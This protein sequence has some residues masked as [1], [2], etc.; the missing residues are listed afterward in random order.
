M[1]VHRLLVESV[2]LR[3]L[4]R[5]PGGHDVLRARVDRCPEATGQK[6]PGSLARKGACDSTADR[7]SG[8]VDHPNLVVEQ[9]LWFP[10]AKDTDTMTSR[11]RAR[12]LRPVSASIRVNTGRICAMTRFANRVL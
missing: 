6:E 5:S 1:P 7:T 9:H 11:N 3:R 4:G 12:D 2:D 8:S 10:F